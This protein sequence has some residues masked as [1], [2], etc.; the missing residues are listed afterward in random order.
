MEKLTADEQAAI[1]A[2]RKASQE[3]V[4]RVGQP[5]DH[6]TPIDQ[7]PAENDERVTMTVPKDFVLTLD[8][9]R[10]VK[11]TQGICSVPVMSQ[12]VSGKKSEKIAEHWYVV[13]HGCKTYTPPAKAAVE[14]PAPV[15]VAVLGSH[16]VPAQAD[17]TLPKV[18]V[19]Q[20]TLA[21]QK[22]SGLT[23]DDWNALSDDKRGE[24]IS[25]EITSRQRAAA[26]G[27]KKAA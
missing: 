23:V 14:A 5:G 24:C 25:A 16:A 18:D 26:V 22:A 13:A 2:G 27:K 11:F 20:A 8:D 6:Y 4:K 3:L 9:H 21:A 17:A 10:Q 7:L 15:H 12:A 1:A 19:G